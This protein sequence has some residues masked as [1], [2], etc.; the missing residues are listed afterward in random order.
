VL[1]F[2]FH[3]HIARKILRHHPQSCN[4]A[5][6]RDIG[7]FLEKMLAAGGTRDGRQLLRETTGEDLSTR[8][9]VE[10]FKPLEAWLAEQNRGRTIGW[11]WWRRGGTRNDLCARAI[12][13]HRAV[14]PLTLALGV[15]LRGFAASR[16]MLSISYSMDSAKAP[17]GS[18]SLRSN[19]AAIR[20]ASGRSRATDRSPMA[21]ARWY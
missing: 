8:A 9:M 10:Y 3:D 13:A 4:Y 2:Q 11:D 7:A 20:Q 17:C 18:T 6:N 12:R 19:G 16:E 21:T 15:P 14:T 5:G 1:K